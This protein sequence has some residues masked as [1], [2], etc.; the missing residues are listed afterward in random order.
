MTTI[1]HIA[2]SF[3]LPLILAVSF[4]SI[5]SGR[6]FQVGGNIS[7]STTP[8]KYALITFADALDTM[9]RFT[10]LSD[11]LGNY[12]LSII[13]AVSNGETEIP[14]AMN[15]YQ[16]YPNP[17]DQG[18]IIR[19]EL[20]DDESVS[21]KI[22]N[23]LGQQVKRVNHIAIYPGRH[24]IAWDGKDDLG[25]DVSPGIYFYQLLSTNKTQVKKMVHISPISAPGRIQYPYKGD[26]GVTST[27]SVVRRDGIFHVSI[28][29]VDSTQPY[30]VAQR[31][32]DFLISGDT[33]LNFIAE[34]ARIILGRSIDGVKIGDDSMTVINKIGQ[35]DTIV[36]DDFVGVIFKYYRVD[37]PH[38]FMMIS[39]F[40]DS[41]LTNGTAVFFLE[42]DSPYVGKTKEGVGIG[43]PR[44]ITWQLL[45][46]PTNTDSSGSVIE[47]Y[48]LVPPPA[49]NP[50]TGIYF[51]YPFDDRR[52]IR[53]KMSG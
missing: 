51:V 2:T 16:N 43:T 24:E 33:I 37:N 44:E 18:T 21:L 3:V 32:S 45:G 5:L 50:P 39:I 22:F 7:S 13:T 1:E 48:Y 40:Q 41:L 42:V 34:E 4:P 12:Q 20:P 47:D 10:I 6:Q 27:A 8:I 14:S 49:G 36:G 23:I 26:A 11:S 19:Y 29:S 46:I 31:I 17:F 9:K 15:L 53:I 28:E 25:K 52:I 30:V 35:P 38:S